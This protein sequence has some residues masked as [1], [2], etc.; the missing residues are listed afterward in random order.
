MQKKSGETSYA[1]SMKETED[2]DKKYMKGQ[3]TLPTNGRHTLMSES[4]YLQHSQEGEDVTQNKKHPI[5]DNSQREKNKKLNKNQQRRMKEER[6]LIDC[7][8]PPLENKWVN[9]PRL[10][11]ELNRIMAI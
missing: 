10:P 3:K 11:D 9:D 4:E 2:K 6:R 8:I 1:A 7:P 5:T